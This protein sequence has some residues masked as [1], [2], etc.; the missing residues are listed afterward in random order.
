[1]QRISIYVIRNNIANYMNANTKNTHSF[2]HYIS[3][4]Y[5]AIHVKYF[6]SIFILILKLL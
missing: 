6:V 4:F 3:I 5:F 2:N 1:M